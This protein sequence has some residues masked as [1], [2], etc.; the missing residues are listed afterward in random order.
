MSPRVA[1]MVLAAGS[2]RRMGSR[3]K[4]LIDVAGTPM[5]RRVAETALQAGLEPVVTVV[6]HGGEEVRQALRGLSLTLVAN[7]RPQDGLSRSLRLGVEALPAVDAAV[8]LLGDMP[9]VRSA[10]VEALVAAFDPSAS[11]EICVPVHGGSRGNP[12]LWSARFFP[13]ISALEGDVGARS[14]LARHAEVV[15]EVTGVGAGVLQDVDTPEA[16]AAATRMGG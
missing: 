3:N 12:V 11:R 7:D 8:V 2:S 16:L 6:G 4:L 9:W 13:E 10:D 15:H 5:V 1:G 14:L